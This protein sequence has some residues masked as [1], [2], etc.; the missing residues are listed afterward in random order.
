MVT[1]GDVG[2]R[3]GKEDDGGRM[4]DER[5]SSD[6]VKEVDGEGAVQSWA[7]V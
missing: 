7:R 3:V 2:G 5:G 4:V 6:E 1:G